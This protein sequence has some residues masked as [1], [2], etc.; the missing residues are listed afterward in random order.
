MNGITDKLFFRELLTL[1]IILDTLI[2]NP[3]QNIPP[4]FLRIDINIL[5]LLLRIDI[6]YNFKYLLIYNITIKTIH[7]TVT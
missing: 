2:I 3:F 4:L 7:K 5:P 6:K 1:F